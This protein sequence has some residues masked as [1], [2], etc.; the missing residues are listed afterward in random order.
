MCAHVPSHVPDIYTGP[1]QAVLNGDP[2]PVSAWRAGVH[3][4]HCSRP[5]TH[6]LD[7]DRLPGASVNT[8]MM[9]TVT[10]KA[11]DCL[12]SVKYRL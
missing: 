10:L 4:T 12:L 5:V 1:T 11:K 2:P 9:N 6:Y 3:Y 8:Q 7:A